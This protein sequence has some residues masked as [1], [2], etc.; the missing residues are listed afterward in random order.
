[1]ATI[2]TTA[3][4]FDRFERD[5]RTYKWLNCYPIFLLSKYFRRAFPKLCHELILSYCCKRSFTNIQ[6]HPTL[7]SSLSVSSWPVL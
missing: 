5:P 3:F 1:M 7:L 6:R 2:P 4:S